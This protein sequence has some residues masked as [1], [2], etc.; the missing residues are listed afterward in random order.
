MGDEMSATAQ[1]INNAFDRLKNK[2]DRVWDIVRVP[3]YA[4]KALDYI[5]E[6]DL[7]DITESAQILLDEKRTKRERNMI[8]IV[9]DFRLEPVIEPFSNIPDM[10]TF[11]GHYDDT[12]PYL[13]FKAGRDLF[14]SDISSPKKY[15]FDAVRNVPALEQILNYQPVDIEITIKARVQG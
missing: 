8:T 7:V 15:P 10:S 4:D 13:M 1:K 3:F 11:T 12:G 2:T 9:K 6:S 14:I 5:D